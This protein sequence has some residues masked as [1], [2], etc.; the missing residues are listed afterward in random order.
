MTDEPS[1]P[2]A[3]KLAFDTKTDAEA[4]AIVAD[5]QRGVSLKAYICKYCHLWH[6]AS[7]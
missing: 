1:L 5:W 6:L 3:E 4:S 7:R 2:C